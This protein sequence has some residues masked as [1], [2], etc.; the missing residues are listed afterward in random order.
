VVA[1]E[2]PVTSANR[3]SDRGVGG[4]IGSTSNLV[5]CAPAPTSLYS[6][7]TGAHQPCFGWTPPIRAREGEWIES[8]DSIPCE[9]N[10]TG[11][12]SC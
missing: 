5:L 12:S 3:R 1:A 2:L 11:S 6:A 4:A 10:L 7:A 9:I 8:L